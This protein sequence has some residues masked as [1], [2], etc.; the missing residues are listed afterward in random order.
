MNIQVVIDPREMLENFDRE[1]LVDYL[2]ETMT[3]EEREIV[4]DSSLESIWE[5]IEVKAGEEFTRL[6]DYVL[7]RLDE[8]EIAG[9]LEENSNYFIS[10]NVEELIEQV[11]VA[12][13]IDEVA[14]LFEIKYIG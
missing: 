6:R 7:G 8:E 2:K 1:V 14:E 11:R 4:F 5:A 10:E 9:Y 12:G 3:I 13:Y